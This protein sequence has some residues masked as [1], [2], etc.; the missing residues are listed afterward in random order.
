V[1]WTGDAMIGDPPWG[2]YFIVGVGIIS[3]KCKKQPTIALFTMEAEYMVTIHCTNKMVWLRQLLADVICM[4]ERPTSIMCDN[5][6]CIACAKNPTHHSHPNI[7][8]YNII[9]LERN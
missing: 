8:M 9:S 3:W 7:S 1:D 2:M 5:H 6:G 4:Q